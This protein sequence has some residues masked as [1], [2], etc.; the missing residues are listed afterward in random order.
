MCAEYVYHF[1]QAISD[2][3]VEAA[4]AGKPG[5]RGSVTPAAPQK[6]SPAAASAAAVES[7]A[8]EAEEEGEPAKAANSGAHHFSCY[9]TPHTHTLVTVLEHLSSDPSSDS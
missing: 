8:T 5:G 7:P 3:D 4:A 2:E 1:W 9:Y 6:R